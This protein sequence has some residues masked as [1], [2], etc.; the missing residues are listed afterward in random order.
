M[1][2]KPGRHYVIELQLPSGR[3]YQYGPY[4]GKTAEQILDRIHTAYSMAEPGQ[5]PMFHF[6]DEQQGLNQYL[7]LDHFCGVQIMEAVPRQEKPSLIQGDEAKD[8][9][10]SLGALPVKM[11]KLH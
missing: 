8:A 4:D 10:K 7:L 5:R 9:M 1:S 3:A 6:E 11:G 2:I